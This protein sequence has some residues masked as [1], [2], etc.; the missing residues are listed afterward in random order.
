MESVSCKL[1][2]LPFVVW[3][4]EEAASCYCPCLPN[5]LQNAPCLCISKLAVSISMARVKLAHKE[6]F[7][8][9]ASC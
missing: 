9:A 8:I 4:F 3:N 6:N 2:K 1:L 5:K 7:L